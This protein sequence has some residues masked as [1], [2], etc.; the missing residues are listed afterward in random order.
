MNSFLVI[1][2][3]LLSTHSHLPNT[4]NSFLS[5]LST[6]HDNGNEDGHPTSK[7]LRLNKDVV[8]SSTIA[9][10]SDDVSLIGNHTTFLFQEHDWPNLEHPVSSRNQ[11]ST[12]RT[13][14]RSPQW[15]DDETTA[16][17]FMFDVRNSTFC[18]EGVDALVNSESKSICS[19]AGSFVRFSSS[20]I[21][22]SSDMC[23]FVIM[24][25]SNG[26]RCLGSTVMLCCVRHESGWDW[27]VPF[28][29]VGDGHTPLVS[30]GSA[31]LCDLVGAELERISVI[32]TGLSLESQELI[33][34]TGPLFSFGVSE[35]RCCL[36]VSGCAPLRMETDLHSSTLV[37][38]SS[39]SSPFSPS[40]QLFGS[41]VSQLVVGSCVREST[42]HDSGTAMMSPNL[43]G[44]VICLNT[45][46]SSCIRQSNAVKVFQNQNLTQGSRLKNVTSDVASVSFTLCTFNE[47]TIAAGSNG[48]GAAIYLRF[49][50]SSLTV[51]TCFFHKC[52]C[53]KTGDDGG[54]IH[55]TCFESQKLPLTLSDSSFTECSANEYGGSIN[56]KYPSPISVDCCLFENS[57]ADADGTIYVHS[58]DITV[59]NSAFIN[60]SANSHSGGISFFQVT[61]LS[62]SFLRFRGCFCKD[63][64]DKKDIYFWLNA[65]TQFT[66]K[67]FQSCDSTSGA[68]NVYFGS[69]RKEDRDLIPQVSTY[70]TT[71]IK[72]LDVSFNENEATVRVSTATSIIGTMNVLL[73]GSNVPRLV[74]VVFG[75]DSTSSNLG[76]AVV[77]SG[78]N[79][80]LPRADY[81]FR[82]AAVTG[83]RLGISFGPFIFE[84]SSTPKDWN[85]TEIVVSGVNLR[86]GSYWMLVEKDGI[87]VNVTLTRSDSTTLIGTAPLH[88]STA[89][90]RLDWES[91]YFV[92]KVMWEGNG[93]EPEQDIPLANSITFTTPI[94]PPRITSVVCALNGKKDVVIVELTGAKLT[95]AG[96]PV[97]LKGTSNQI[98]S[99]GGLFNV[100]STKCFV[101]FSIGE[102]ESRTDVVFGGKYELLS[103]G[104]ES[105]SILVEA[106]LFIEVPHPPRITTLTAPLELNSNP[107]VLSVSGEN[108]PADQN[109][110]VT[111]T[112]GH[113]FSVSFSS[114]SAG[115]ATVMIG[116]GG[117]MQYNTS[118]TIKSVIRFVGGEDEHILFPSTPFRT[119]LGPTLSS[120]SCLFSTSSPDIL[121]VS[122]STER[123]PQE[124]VHLAL[125]SNES[126][127]KKVGIPIAP[128]K[129]SAG[130]VL[131]EVYNESNTLKYG[132]E[133]SIID[134]TS[135]KITAVV[136][137][138]GFSTPPEP[139]R[140]TS[141]DCSLGGDQQKSAI[142]SLTGVK[143]GGEKGFA[144]GVRKMEGSSLIGKEIELSGKL[145]GGSSSTTH[146]HSVLIFGTVNSL[147]SFGT[148]YQITRFEVSGSVCVVDTDVT[149]SVPAEPPRIV[150]VETRVLNCDRTKMI[151]SLEGRALLS[152]TGKVSLTKGSTTWE[153]SSDVNIVDDTHS[154]AEFIVGKEETS[155]Q[156]KYGEEYTL[157]GSWT[158]SSGFHVEDGITIVVPFLW[159]FTHVEFLFSN[160][161]HTGCFVI[162]SGRDLIVGESLNVTLNSSLSFIATITSETKAQSTEQLIGWPTTLQH[163]TKYTITSIEATNPDDG[164]ILFD[165]AISN[166]TGSLPDD[167]VLFVDCGSTSDSSLLCG[168]RKR[169]CSW[170]EDGWKIVEWIGISS[171]SISIIHNTT[172]KSQVRIGSDHEVVISS[173]PSTKP[174]L[175]VSASSYSSSSLSS[176]MEG[177][178]MVEVVGGRLWIH[179]VD[180]VLSDSP[181]LIFIRMVGGHLTME[182]CS[183][184]STSTTP[185]N[186][187]TSLCL[188]SG[189]AIVLGQATTTITTSTFSELSSGAINMKGG[190]LAFPS[191]KPFTTGLV[192]QSGEM[193]GPTRM[194]IMVGGPIKAFYPLLSKKFKQRLVLIAAY[195]WRYKP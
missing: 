133:Y 104:S 165:P 78:E 191:V 91:E 190:S 159:T 126:P 103:V 16:T 163:N 184:T 180:V 96:L 183:L 35:Q 189:G 98:E 174:E 114:P 87:E 106:G 39:S 158:E 138:S 136:L 40:K 151:V 124:H 45:S 15:S 3:L 59:K 161:L 177:E 46:F 51:T 47:M 123:M 90:G 9:I 139:I 142:V 82:S 128:S 44:N 179:Q 148:K 171:L 14:R 63:D 41:E 144:I 112:S 175:F 119:P 141:A 130:F 61:N 7:I 88:P 49:T 80:V 121:N 101:T 4:P 109:C 50:S 38:V 60:C 92:T 85:T 147:L 79:G 132:T 176:E 27:I 117:E 74:H 62:L 154:T 6:Q 115:T 70:S 135:E 108:L 129:L 73:D 29:G 131:V 185:S 110:T 58:D 99:S 127:S 111:L 137:V 170:I 34:G 54:A 168:D 97:V 116:R 28:V 2:A 43:G 122:L 42:N 118:Y 12:T 11:Q 65:S 157:K 173:G 55:V 17:M 195:I 125:K 192:S 8:I 53:T 24:G 150:Q 30:S 19:L 149:F 107:F 105:S 56:A 187:E 155:D 67:M 152:R 22:S 134:M 32:G 23:P 20:S 145:S 146:T 5:L 120:I 13:S 94:G 143:L 95:S 188:W 83:Y 153:S 21:T 172:Q 181:S 100:S 178:G 194:E 48:G 113:S 31:D 186:S 86:E 64:P 156:L 26:E 75:D 84:A 52:T 57:Q 25:S 89:K 36:G 164:E 66:S 102:S 169:P 18:V 182:T 72:S 71:T 68:P 93:V 167:V 37:N 33:F 193:P 76:T 140:I 77:S 166:T 162:L 1:L 160:T 69:D 10:R 81:V